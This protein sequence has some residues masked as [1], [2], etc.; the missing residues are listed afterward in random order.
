[1]LKPLKGRVFLKIFETFNNISI[2][3]NLLLLGCFRK[4]NNLGFPLGPSLYVYVYPFPHFLGILKGWWPWFY[5]ITCINIQTP[6]C[7]CKNSPI[8]FVKGCQ[9]EHLKSQKSLAIQPNS[10]LTC[11]RMDI[12]EIVDFPKYDVSVQMWSLVSQN[13]P[14]IRVEPLLPYLSTIRHISMS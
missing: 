11:W 1:M 8:L 5:L 4:N 14:S 2:K 6:L 13:F 7:S 9:F 3:H 12:L 10:I